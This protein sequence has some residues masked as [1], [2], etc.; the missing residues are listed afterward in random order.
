MGAAVNTDEAL[1][2][3]LSPAVH[4]GSQQATVQDW[5]MALGLGTPC[6]S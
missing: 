6:D 5:L 4:D 3:H 2:L 1:L